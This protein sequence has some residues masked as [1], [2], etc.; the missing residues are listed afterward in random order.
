MHSPLIK[1]SPPPKA[2]DDGF[3]Y[4]ARTL[5]QLKTTHTISMHSLKN[6]FNHDLLT[7]VGHQ[8]VPSYNFTAD[9]TSNVIKILRS[10]PTTVD[11][12]K[13]FSLKASTK[14]S[15][16][17]LTAIRVSSRTPELKKTELFLYSPFVLMLHYTSAE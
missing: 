12:P 6:C 11:K 5:G 3:Y 4:L 8:L 1:I 7:S 14:I 16:S 17:C 2:S 9:T 15:S 13:Y 10:R